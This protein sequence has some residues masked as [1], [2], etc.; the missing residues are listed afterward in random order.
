MYSRAEE[1]YRAELAAQL[2]QQ[3]EEISQCVSEPAVAEVA[4]IA[5]ATPLPLTE[6]VIAPMPTA[7]AVAPAPVMAGDTAA[8]P[9]VAET[10]PAIAAEAPRRLPAPTMPRRR[11]VQPPLTLVAA[12]GAIAI[13]AILGIIFTLLPETAEPPAVTEAAA[14]GPASQPAPIPQ[15]APATPPQPVPATV[16]TQGSLPYDYNAASVAVS[17][18]EPTTAAPAATSYIPE[19]PRPAVT[20]QTGTAATDDTLRNAANAPVVRAA[21]IESA[22]SSRPRAS[23]GQL[24]ITSTP[25]GARVTINGIGWGQTPLTIGHL[26]LGAKTVRLTRDGY[27]AQQRSVMISGEDPSQSLHATLRRR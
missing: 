24:R 4:P 12:F 7:Q 11:R 3:Q 22:E 23:E 1:R 13:A 18:L 2:Q 6:P 21:R 27:A 17:S 26:P 15:A 19:A 20:T 14:A 25:A 8:T 10:A 9:F 5:A 16:T